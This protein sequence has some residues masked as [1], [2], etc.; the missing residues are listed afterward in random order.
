MDPIEACMD[1]KE[2][3]LFDACMVPKEIVL[4]VLFDAILYLPADTQ[5]K[6]CRILPDSD[7]FCRI[8]QNSAQTRKLM[9]E[10][11]GV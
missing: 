6:F 8:L 10:T 1:P 3:V 2:I 11:A 4:I 5:Q 9:P 7:E